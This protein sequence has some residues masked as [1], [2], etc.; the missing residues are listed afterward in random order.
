MLIGLKIPL[1]V[2]P[3]R[4]IVSYF[5]ILS[6][7]GIVRNNLLLPTLALK[8]SIVLLLTPTLSFSSFVDSYMIWVFLRP[9]DLLY[10]VT[11][12][13][14]FRLRVMMYFMNILNTLRSTI[15]LCTIIFCKD[16]FVSVLL[17][18]LISWPM[19]SPMHIHLDDFIILFPNSSWHLYYN[20]EFE[21]GC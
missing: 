14:Q 15:I 6:S 3:P 13:V 18:P 21:E 2:V 4:V 1:I 10:F 20:L 19:C 12:E 8:L 7:R 9:P 16:L 5:M 17:L 11:I